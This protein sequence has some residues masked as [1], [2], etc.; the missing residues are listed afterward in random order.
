M[1]DREDRPADEPGPPVPPDLGSLPPPQWPVAPTVS[2]QDNSYLPFS[3]W[4]YANFA[5]ALVAGIIIGPFL[6][7]IVITV[8]SGP[9]AVDDTP[10][11][12]LLGVQAFSSLTALYLISRFRGSG[13]WRDDYGFVINPRHVWGLV[14][15]MVLQVAVALLTYPLIERFADLSGGEIALF[16]L[17]VAVLTPIFEEIVFRGMLLG[18]LVKSMNRHWAAAISA[19]AFGGTHLLDPNALLVVPGLIVVGLVLAYTAYYSKNLSLPIFVHMGV[20]GLAVLLLAFQDEL[21][22][23]AETVE[24]IVWFV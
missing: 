22:E 8:V 16:A 7:V 17:L 5:L 14:A 3:N 9:G 10:T 20:N 21:E 13:S 12:V 11:L 23:L 2:L 24:T 4:S 1:S 19:V 6:A 18:R 15:G